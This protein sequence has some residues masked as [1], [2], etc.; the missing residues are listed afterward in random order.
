MHWTAAH[1]SVWKACKL[2]CTKDFS[3]RVKNLKG[4]NDKGVKLTW[5]CILWPTFSEIS[6][7]PV[8]SVFL[9]CNAHL[10][11]VHYKM[12]LIL[13]TLWKVK[14]YHCFGSFCESVRLLTGQGS[15][16]NHLPSL[17]YYC[18]FR[19]KH[20]GK[21]LFE[22]TPFPFLSFFFPLLLSSLL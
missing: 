3:W 21:I 13:F 1:L 2:G 16:H 7:S 17:S 12:I 6:T 8:N 19:K 22:F 20:M 4:K 11:N 18:A 5:L 9:F 15:E 10:Q 14:L